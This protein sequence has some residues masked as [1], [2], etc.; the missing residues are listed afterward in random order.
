M[1]KEN[2]LERRKSKE[3]L[4]TTDEASKYLR[5]KKGTLAI[6]RSTKRYEVPYIRVGRLIRYRVSD[7]EE[8]IEKY[9]E[10]EEVEEE[11]DVSELL[12]SGDKQEQKI[13]KNNNQKGGT[14]CQNA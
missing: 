2:E 3:E 4:L 8:F 7:L 1:A 10:K 6:W 11:W 9:Y 14:K 12:G 13:K 5:V